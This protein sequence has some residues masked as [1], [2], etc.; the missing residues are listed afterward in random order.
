[1]NW[2][3]K[4]AAVILIVVALLIGLGSSAFAFQSYDGP[5]EAVN[6]I[7]PPNGKQCNVR[8]VILAA[9]DEL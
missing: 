1:M 8:G 3:A 2:F 6:K 4:S 7:D 9:A 5:R